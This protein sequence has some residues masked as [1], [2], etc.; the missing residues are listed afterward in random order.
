MPNNHAE[1]E[2]RPDPAAGTA[3]SVSDHE[4]DCTQTSAPKME[5]DVTE[6]AREYVFEPVTLDSKV[7]LG[8]VFRLLEACPTLAHVARR[9]FAEK[10]CAKA[11]K[12]GMASRLNHFRS[13]RVSSPWS[14]ISSGHSVRVRRRTHL[15]S[16]STFAAWDQNVSK[17]RRH[18]G[19]RRG[20]ASNG[21]CR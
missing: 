9:E 7:T 19:V 14:G 18:T 17:T 2:P 10:L 1:P 11:N 21:R 13:S 8:G 5:A 16:D 6:R 20:S 3:C 15:C 12:G 4:A